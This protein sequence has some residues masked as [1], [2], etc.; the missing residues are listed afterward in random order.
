MN[1]NTKS[2]QF[3]VQIKKW[4]FGFSIVRILTIIVYLYA[5]MNKDTESYEIK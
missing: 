2:V 4:F 5:Q 3:E 1:N